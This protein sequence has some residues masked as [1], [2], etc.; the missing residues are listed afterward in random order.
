MIIGII[1]GS[2]IEN[3]TIYDIAYKAGSLIAQ[4][5]WYLICGGLSGVMEAAAKGA[6]DH[7]GITIGILPQ[8]ETKSAN[9]YIKIPIATGM[10][11]ARNH[12]IVHTADILLA[13]DGEFGTLN[14]ISAALSL[15]KPVI[16]LKTWELDK[17]KDIDPK[18]FIKVNTP[19]E[20]IKI[21]KTYENT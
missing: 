18:L 1:G 6:Y 16:A 12:I 5:N 4:N 20:A 11:Y 17:I 8:S 7:K 14:E 10:G 21:I 19:E 9:S 13:I 15:N 2:Q 3:K